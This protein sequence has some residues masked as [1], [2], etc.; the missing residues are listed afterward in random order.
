MA[1]GYLKRLFMN[2]HIVI[3]GNAVFLSKQFVLQKIKAYTLER[4]IER[5]VYQPVPIDGKPYFDYDLFPVQSQKKL[6]NKPDLIA[7]ANEATHNGKLETYKAAFNEAYTRH[8]IKYIDL[9]KAKYH[10]VKEAHIKTAARLMAAVEYII[11]QKKEHNN[12]DTDVMHRAFVP[13]FGKYK[14]YNSFANAVSKAMKQGAESVAVKKTW[15]TAPLN[16]K[17]IPVVDRFWSAG[18]ASIPKKYGPVA[19]HRKLCAMCADAG[20]EPPSMSWVKKFYKEI[21]A[22]PALYKA[23]NGAD[24]AKKKDLYAT[25]SGGVYANERWL[26]DGKQLPFFGEKYR[27]YQCFIIMDDYSTKIISFA[28]G[29][30]ENTI[31]IMDAFKTAINETGCLPR[32]IL[33]DNHSFNKT[34]EA[35]YFKDAIND[36]G[37]VYHADS[38]SQRNSG[39]ERSHMSLDYFFKDYYGFTGQGIKAKNSNAR[40]S[41]D[42]IDKVAKDY[43]TEQEIFENCVAVINQ[44]NNRPYNGSTPEQLFAASEQPYSFKL[45]LEQQIKVTTNKA[46]F[47]ISRGQINITR[48]GVT[49]EFI[50]DTDSTFKHRDC[51]VSVRYED[52]RKGIYVFDKKS[53]EFLFEAYPKPVINSTVARQTKEDELEL[54]KLA[55]RKKALDAKGRKEIEELM[56][57]ALLENPDAVDILNRHTTPKE[58]IKEAERQANLKR[59]AIKAGIDFNKVVKRN[60]SSEVNLSKIL[61]LNTTPKHTIKAKG[62]CQPIDFAKEF[63]ND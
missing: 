54:Y 6:G 36:I 24:E 58:I 40:P 16:V 50:F 46:N 55:A 33:G 35:A 59:D 13:V 28:V 22:N 53:D 12:R 49:H 48:Q 45:S 2:K 60:R 52:L 47:K 39:I 21:Q 20:K 18:V 27:R 5:E 31:I 7:L 4:A 56:Q 23:R 3:E 1:K 8:Y 30:S 42:Y 29:E 26:V 17:T 62:D 32:E 9:L 19:I 57:K 37:T 10:Q 44:W 15:Y 41:Q 34:S 11:T 63:N 51:E 61:P 14:S 25:L 43:L 38:N